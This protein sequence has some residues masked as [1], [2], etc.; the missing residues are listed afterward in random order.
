MGNEVPTMG[1]LVDLLEKIVDPNQIKLLIEA[2]EDED[3]FDELLQEHSAH[4]DSCIFHIR[5]KLRAACV[6]EEDVRHT[7]H[8]KCKIAYEQFLD[9]IEVSDT[10]L[11]RLGL[12]T[13]KSLTKA[14]VNLHPLDIL[15]Q[16]SDTAALL[17]FWRDKGY[18]I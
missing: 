18:L 15:V 16:L 2:A 14:G 7:D 6:P 5:K 11:S 4:L 12:S 1:E 9:Q 13:R 3:H 8:P 10:V 17:K